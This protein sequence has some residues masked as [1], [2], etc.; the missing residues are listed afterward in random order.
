VGVYYVLSTQ[1]NLEIRHVESAPA[2]LA[3]VDS[4]FV[5]RNGR[6][7]VL[8][9]KPFK[10]VGVNRYNLM[11]LGGDPYAGCAGVFS[12][13]D[14][15]SWF[16]ELEGMGVTSVRFWVFQSFTKGGT[17]MSR[18]DY[19]L[20]LAR[21]KGIKV[22]PV[23]ENH[24]ADCTEG[25]EKPEAWYR[26]G[27]KLPYGV[28][29]LSFRDYAAQ[30]VERYRDEPVIMMWQLMNEAETSHNT[31]YAFTD[32]MGSLIK[33]IDGNH[34][35]SLGTIGG[36]QSGAQFTEYRVLHDIPSIDIAEYHD[37]H[38]ETHPFPDF[39]S[40]NSLAT[41]FSD[42]MT[43]DKPIMMGEAGIRS[44]CAERD[45]Y[46]PSERAQL[47]QGKMNE[48]FSRGGAAYLLWSYRDHWQAPIEE[49]DFTPSDPL[50]G[51]IRAQTSKL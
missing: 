42:A 20:Q 26:E 24:W 2:T 43:L 7:L 29:K 36:G 18:F 13:E 38:S 6:E 4:S 30:L 8:H 46:G 48:F 40:F 14:L 39:D 49:F 22:I 11:T 31:L 45:C 1:K 5:G 23:L 33:S 9:G 16:T 27:Y 32:D 15:A 10:S 17:D 21:E 37:Y 51:V 35:L 41:R 34:L 28:Y 47:F 19:V 12:D 3:V 44:G 25:G 50:T